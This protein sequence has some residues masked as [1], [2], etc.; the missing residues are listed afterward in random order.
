MQPT[1]LA[2]TSMSDIQSLFQRALD[3]LKASQSK[4]CFEILS[5]IM[6]TLCTQCETLNLTL[7]S[8]LE[9]NQTFLTL[10]AY[11]YNFE[12]D[13]YLKFII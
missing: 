3:L 12:H 13:L 7:E 4:H 5:Q 1:L 8:I 2:Q 9:L 6:D 11:Y 10:F